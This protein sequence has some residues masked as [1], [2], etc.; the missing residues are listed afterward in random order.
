MSGTSV[1]GIDAALVAF[2]EAQGQ[3]GFQLLNTHSHPLPP[4]TKSQ[5]HALTLA[6]HD[7]IARMGALDQQLGEAFAEAANILLTKADIQPSQITAIG[8]H[9]QTIRHQP[10]HQGGTRFSLQIADPNVIA[11]RTGILT[12]ADFRRRDIACGGQGAPLA[13]A[14]HQAQLSSIEQPRCIVNIG[15]IA[16]ITNLPL[17]GTVLGFDTGPGN[18][19][20]DAWIQQCLATPFDRDGAWAAGAEADPALLAMLLQHPFLQRPPPKSTGPEDFNL[21]WLQDLLDNHDSGLDPARVQATLLEFTATTVA[22]AIANHCQSRTEVFVCGG[23]AHN[24]QLLRRLQVHL[25]TNPLAT[26]KALGLHPDWVE[27]AAFA[28]LAKQH[29]DGL[30]G[31]LPEVTGAS[32]A[33]VLGAAYS[34]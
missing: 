28:W 7:E 25:P 13:P 6:G 21:T 4:D 27:A 26:T 15:G 31:N 11:E 5:I 33:V 9:G 22:T 17:G 30:P 20:M 24:Q 1:D 34:G 32:R 2:N 3:P 23:G 19:L 29:V 18:T 12:I 16:N 14:F 10:G 8:S